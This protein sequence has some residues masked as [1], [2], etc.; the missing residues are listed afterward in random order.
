MKVDVNTE[1]GGLTLD[2]DFLI[3]FGKEPGGPSFAHEI[4]LVGY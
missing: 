2:P 4:R 1:T 3:D